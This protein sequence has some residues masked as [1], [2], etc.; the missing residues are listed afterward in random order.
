M[1]A[2]GF[3]QYK[4]DTSIYFID[5]KTRELVISIVYDNNVYFM[6]SKDSPLL[7]ELKQKYITNENV[8]I[9]K[10]PS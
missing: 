3:K 5:E 10:K 6:N 2:L 7:L 8:M 4:S 9:L 1:L